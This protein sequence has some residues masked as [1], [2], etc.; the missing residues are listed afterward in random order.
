ECLERTKTNARVQ[1]F[2]TDLDP[3]AVQVARTGRYPIASAVDISNE[4]LSR[5]FVPE[6]GTLRVNKA[7]REMLVF[8]PQNLVKD[9]PFTSIDLLSCR[10]MLIYFKPELQQKVLSLFHYTL[11]PK[12]LLFLGSSESL[13]SFEDSFR[14]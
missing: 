1:I 2:G 14:V 3:A 10:N 12:G 7:V 5:F 9:P 4:R 11:L 13:G 6:D 8:A